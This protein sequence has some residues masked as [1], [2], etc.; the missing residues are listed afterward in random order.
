MTWRSPELLPM[1]VSVT[2]AHGSI[3][4]A[5][6]HVIVKHP[7]AI[8]AQFGHGEWRSNLAPLIST[9]RVALSIATSAGSAP[10]PGVQ[11]TI[12]WCDDSR[13]DYAGK[14]GAALKAIVLKL[15]RIRVYRW[16]RLP[17]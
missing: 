10:S 12:G 6:K 16:R 11:D 17:L 2:L 13:P 9:G 4:M 7:S 1:I 5:G 3:R 15:K 8:L 14:V